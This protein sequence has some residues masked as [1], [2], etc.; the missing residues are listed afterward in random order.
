MAVGAALT[1]LVF[2]VGTRRLLGLRLPLLRTLLAGVIAFF[3]AQPIISAI[4]G[5]SVRRAAPV[6]PGLWFVLLGV[7]IA[8]LVGMIFL[9]VSEALVPSGSLPGPVYAAR[10]LR[11][12]A[13]RTRRYAEIS[14]ILVRRGLL[15]YQRGGRRSELA[16]AEGRT[17]LARALRL[18]LEDGGVTFVKL[19]QVLSTR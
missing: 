16:T 2:A 19:G 14:R 18:A 7:V 6:L 11:R 9:V 5:P 4:G 8:L 12:Q 10:S 3:V 13:G 1:I 15:P 17:R